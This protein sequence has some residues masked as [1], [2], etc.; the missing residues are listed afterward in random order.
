MGLHHK[1]TCR[2]RYMRDYKHEQDSPHELERT[3]RLQMR[4]R[5]M[6][7]ENNRRLQL[8]PP[9]MP[10]STQLCSVSH[11]RSVKAVNGRTFFC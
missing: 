1:L 8:A 7:C 6:H 2:I 3:S 10:V 5:F 11:C 9:C 4:P